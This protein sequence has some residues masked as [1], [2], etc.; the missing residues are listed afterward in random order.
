M[1]KKW[2]FFIFRNRFKKKRQGIPLPF[3]YHYLANDTSCCHICIYTVT[4][5][6]TCNGNTV[7]SAVCGVDIVSIAHVNANVAD[8]AVAAGI[9][10]YQIPSLQIRLGNSYTIVCHGSGI[11]VQRNTEITENSIYKAGTIHTCIQVCAAP[12]IRGADKLFRISNNFFTFAE[13]AEE[14]P[15]EGSSPLRIET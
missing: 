4:A 10:E 3:L 11:S 5:T 8:G 15:R 14:D 6:H 2:G 9:E 1:P 13:D 12:Y 7:C